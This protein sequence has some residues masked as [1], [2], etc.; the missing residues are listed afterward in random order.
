LNKL[1]SLTSRQSFLHYSPINAK[2]ENSNGDI[3]S[4]FKISF[5]PLSFFDFAPH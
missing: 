1:D 2:N 3:G 4:A 5:V